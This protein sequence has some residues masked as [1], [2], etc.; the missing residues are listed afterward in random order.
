MNRKLKNILLA[1]LA[2]VFVFAIT[3]CAVVEN[4]YK[5]I[6]MTDLAATYTGEATDGDGNLLAPFDV[7]YADAFN[8]GDF[9]YDKTSALLKMK[10]GFKGKITRNLRNC[11]FETMESFLSTKDGEWYRATVKSGT[12]V[13]TAIK[14]ARSL[15]EVVVADYNYVYQNEDVVEYETSAPTVDCKDKLPEKVQNN[16]NSGQQWYLT[17]SGIQQAWKYL[18]KE[19]YDA[20]GSPSVTVAVIDTGVD[21]T[22]PDLKANMWVNSAET[23]GNGIDDDGNGYIDDIHGVDVIANNGGAASID[24]KKVGDPMDDHGHGTHVAGIIA[25]SNNKAGIVGVAYNTKIMA[26]K[27]GQHTGVFTQ[28]DIA[29]AILYAYTMGADVIN[30]S[31]GGSACSIAVQDALMQAYTSATLVA[32]AGNDS[33]PN[34]YADN[35]RVLGDYLPNYPGALSYV[36][37][38]MSVDYRGVE[39]LFTNWDVNAFNTVEYEMY[40][41]GEAMMSTLP[42]GRYGK[43]SGTSMATPMVSGAAALLR[44][45]Y[46]DRDMYPSKFIMAQ[47]AATSEDSAICCNPEDHT[48]NGNVHNLPMMLNVY[49]ALTKLPKPDVYLN[50]YYLFDNAT[51]SDANNGDGVIDAG[52]TV[53]IAPVLRNRWGMSSDTTITIDTL[54]GAEGA[55]IADPY[56]TIV[57]GSVNYGSV[58]TYSTADKLVRDG[59]IVKDCSD[60]LVIKIA[61]N[62]P[63]DYLVKLNVT[64][65]CQ[66]ALDGKDNATYTTKQSGVISFWVRNGVL[67]PSQINEDMT[68]TKENYYIIENS[69]YIA[70]GVTVTVEPGTQIQFWSDDPQDPYADTYI[71]YLNVAGKF[72]TKGTAEDPVLLFPSQMM[73]TYVVD[74]RKTSTGYVDLQYTTITN[75]KVNVTCADHC[76]FNQN[77]VKRLNYRYLSSGKV[78][79][80]SCYAEIYGE[81][82]INSL[83]YKV[84]GASNTRLNLYGIF[85]GCIF[86]DCTLATNV[87]SERIY[88]SCSFVGNNDSA[89]G[90]TYSSAMMEVRQ[91]AIVNILGTVR[92]DVTGTTYAKINFGNSDVGFVNDYIKSMGG[93][94]ACFETQEEFDFVVNALGSAA[95]SNGHYYYILYGKIGLQKDMTWITGDA[96]SLKVSADLSF[97]SKSMASSICMCGDYDCQYDGIFDIN[98]NIYNNRVIIEFPGEVYAESISLAETHVNIDSESQYK[99]VPSATPSTVDLSKLVYVSGDESVATVDKNGVVTPKRQGD[100]TIY[101]YSPDYNVV[102]TCQINVVQKV[103]VKDFDLTM[104]S[105]Q[106]AVGA[107]QQISVALNPTNT[108]ERYVTFAS[109]NESVATVDANGV[110]TAHKAGSATITVTIKGITK[111]IDIT[112]VQAVESIA[113]EDKFYI[114]YVGDSDNSWQPTVLPQTATNKKLNWLSSNPEIAYVDESGSLIRVAPGSATLRATVDNTNLYAELNVNVSAQQQ[115]ISS[116]VVQMDEKN[117]YIIAV[118]AQNELWLFGGSYFKVPTKIADNVKSAIII[119]TYSVTSSTDPRIVFY[120]IDTEGNLAQKKYSLKTL[121]LITENISFTLNNVSKIV[122]Y[123]SSYYALKNDGSVWSWG[124]N[125]HGELGDGTTVDRNKPVQMLVDEQIVDVVAFCHSSAVLTKTGKVYVFGTDSKYTS[126]KL[127][128]TGVVSITANGDDAIF[129]KSTGEN[130]KYWYHGD[131]S[132]SLGFGKDW[133]GGYFYVQNGVFYKNQN[134]VSWDCSKITNVKT[135]LTVHQQDL[136]YLLTED[137]KL[138]GVGQND[139]YQ[140]GDLT[141]VYRNEPTRIFLGISADSNAP[142]AENTNLADGKLLQQQIT[143]DFDMAVL[144]GNEYGYISITDESGNALSLKKQIVLDKLVITPFAGFEQGVTYTLTIPVNAITSAYGTSTEALTYTFV[145]QNNTEIEFVSGSLQSGDVLDSNDFAAQFDYT[146]AVQGDNFDGIAITSGGNKVDGVSVALAD[147]VLSINGTL[148]YGNYTLVVPQGALKD[149][150]GGTNQAISIDFVVAQVIKVVDS[151]VAD[152]DDRVDETQNITITFTNAVASDNFANVSLVDKD[153]NAVEI[154]TAIENNVLTISHNGLAQGMTYTLTVPQGALKDELGNQNKQIS[155]TFTTYAPVEILYSSVSQSNVAIEPEFKLYYNGDVTL[156]STKVA[157]YQG[158]NAVEVSATLNGRVLVVKPL[159][160]LEQNTTYKLVLGEGAVSDERDAL[161]A[162]YNAEFATIVV[163]ERFFWT[164]AELE[165]AYEPYKYYNQYFYNNVILNNFND[166]NVEHW[167]RIQ[168]PGSSTKELI[169]LAGNYWGTTDEEMIDKQIIDFDDYQS[170]ADIV[171]T[172]YLTSA[173]ENVFPFV[174]NVLLFNSDDEAV[175]T[176]SNETVRFV[177]EFNR[178]MDENE[179]LRVRFGSF[180]PYAD[181]E[182]EG[183]FVSPRRWEGIYTLKTT[184]ENGNQFFNISGG[185]AADDKYLGLYETMGRFTFKID[186]TGAQAMIM[187]AQAN[188]TGINLTWVQ[189]D[190]DTLAGYNVYRSYAEDG[191]YT[192]LNSYVLSPETKEFFDDTVEPGKV[193]YYNFTVVKTDLSESKPSGKVVV[194]SYDTM[195]PAIY[196]SP[197]RTAYTGSNLL[198]SATIT[199]NLQISQAKL[200]YRVVGSAEWRSVS[201][202]AFNDRYTGIIPSEYVDLAGIEYYIDAFDGGNHTYKGTEQD[203]YLVTVKLAVDKNSFGDVDGNGTVTTKDALMLLQ[204]ANDLL[205]LTEEQFLRADIDEDG[206]LSASEALCILNYASGKTTTILG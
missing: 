164:T 161:S 57:T 75:P 120:I 181:Y 50:N 53:N 69:T 95:T 103:A 98:S 174:T 130:F 66:N 150:V 12:H 133:Y 32:A 102:A 166:T 116:E 100:V 28:A 8:S 202:T 157:L 194:R 127:M 44:S 21:Y 117:G 149:N 79:D 122:T 38:V 94:L 84:S 107:P 63:N 99:I 143:L 49:D 162:Q 205:N 109:S 36:I 140:L 176:V 125:D 42:G 89:F 144:A 85:K 13:T 141:N 92:N 9:E 41:P 106:V 147:N 35:Y 68:L 163:E 160:A 112:T 23:P 123:N 185:C 11:G 129:R 15:G 45:Y 19:G 1:V 203:P 119:G 59:S 81:E 179:N 132:T 113:F 110:V 30:M 165:K 54:A 167:L 154:S 128:D 192:R 48:I 206:I 198:V 72:V 139:Q 183:N 4:S 200:Y 104:D 16:E 101:V 74:I 108:T 196:H 96:Y 187:Q 65:T 169:G 7:V 180:A 126:A 186:T 90:G 173:P 26:I 138:Y 25:A 195:A 43:L 37:G 121:Q 171:E 204:A 135:V 151:S 158:E 146:F 175:T 189:D 170:Q 70:E 201:M 5:D 76:T 124:N 31:F 193:Y 18:D 20:G 47:L 51:L 71:A 131:K 184:I 73:D 190:F 33:K 87:S 136:V 80:D 111:T 14:K 159:S 168:A 91:G 2:C 39:S 148:D 142:V 145:Y 6:P 178:D 34:E 46:T 17:A 155:T 55:E 82:I 182:I 64:V 172:P 77:Y 115:A 197:V 97:A 153:G 152:G 114:T 61:K 78:R 177:V 52:E 67:L 22:H 134:V 86:V 105:T 199:D 83:I 56:V 3:A 118:T 188:E 58:G 60:P 10:E 88:E 40:A 24:P 62:C 93:H 27:A 156:D 137:G 191:Q 29:E